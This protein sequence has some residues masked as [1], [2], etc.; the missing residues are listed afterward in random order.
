M[1]GHRK[2]E[3]WKHVVYSASISSYFI[4]MPAYD[5]AKQLDTA[6]ITVEHSG[7]LWL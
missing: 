7:R 1:D 2:G 5:A 3:S 6:A 4:H